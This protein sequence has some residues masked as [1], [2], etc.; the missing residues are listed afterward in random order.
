M[1]D[2]VRTAE[3]AL[4]HPDAD[5]DPDIEVTVLP[6]APTGAKRQTPPA[7]TDPAAS[8]AKK[9]AR[10]QVDCK[11]GARCTRRGCGFRHPSPTANAAVS[12]VSVPAAP[13]GAAG[14][15]VP[16]LADPLLPDSR[17]VVHI[18][19]KNQHANKDCRDRRHP[20][21]SRPSA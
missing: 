3:R 19:L 20:N 13:P 8:A 15:Q 21:V 4:A 12:A 17:C 1:E 14:K 2:R 16:I 11:W 9:R 18:L 6:P 10:Q 7:S 5:E